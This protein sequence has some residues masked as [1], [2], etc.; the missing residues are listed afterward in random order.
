M[1]VDYKCMFLY[2]N[3]TYSI[4]GWW[5]LDYNGFVEKNLDPTQKQL[6]DR[7]LT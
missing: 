6:G 7:S 2:E 4:D 3:G 1:V 5:G